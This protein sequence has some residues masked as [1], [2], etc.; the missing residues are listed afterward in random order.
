ML[1]VCSELW[2]QIIASI[3][4]YLSTDRACVDDIFSLLEIFENCWPP[5]SPALQQQAF[6]FLDDFQDWIERTIQADVLRARVSETVCSLTRIIHYMVHYF[7]T[8]L[9]SSTRF[10]D[11]AKFVDQ[12]VLLLGIDARSLRTGRSTWQE[13]KRILA[14]RSDL[15]PDYF[16]VFTNGLNDIWPPKSV[17]RSSS[18][19]TLSSFESNGAPSCR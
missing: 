7:A 11:F 14:S 1:I 15:P 17:S 12:Y 6:L 5:P 2:G 18:S 4:N 3:R 8:D 9:V 10:A 16:P 13:T 19:S